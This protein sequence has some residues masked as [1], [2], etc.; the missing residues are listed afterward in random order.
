M[1]DVVLRK[2]ELRVPVALEVR[3]KAPPLAID[4]VLVAVEHFGVGVGHDGFGNFVEGVHGQLI[5]VVHECDPVGANQVEGRIGG[6]T[7]VAVGLTVDHS[8]AGIQGFKVFEQLSHFW[9]G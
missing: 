8:D 7:N 1:R 9:V 5:I 3:V 2:K 4:L 6:L